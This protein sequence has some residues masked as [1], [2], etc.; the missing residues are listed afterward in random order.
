M[1]VVRPGD[2][3]F[4]GVRADPLVGESFVAGDVA[5]ERDVVAVR[6]PLAL[7]ADAVRPGDGV[8]LAMWSPPS[9]CGWLRSPAGCDLGTLRRSTQP[10]EVARLRYQHAPPRECETGREVPPEGES[11]I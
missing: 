4:A 5:T 1:V 6:W 3:F 9:G 2:G 10:C 11:L 7:A 8:L